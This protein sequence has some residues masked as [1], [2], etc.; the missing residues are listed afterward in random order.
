MLSA[1]VWAELS[2]WQWQNNRTWF[3]IDLAIGVLAFVLVWWRRRFPG[4]VATII[5][6]ASAVSGSAAG[7]STLALF[8]VSTRREWRLILPIAILATLSGSVLATVD[9]SL[10]DDQ[11]DSLLTYAIALL[12]TLA[13]IA[14]TVGWGMYIGSKRE[15]ARTRR[16]RERTWADEEQ[17]RIERARAAER[18]LIAR[19]MHDVLAHRISLVTM[20][21]GALTYRKDLPPEQVQQT[22]HVIHDTAHQALVELR[23]VLG[24]L[25]DDTGDALPERPQP[26]ADD[27]P[28][29]LTEAEQN[30]MDVHVQS[31]GVD[32]A[33]IP[34]VLG[35]T[36]YRIVQE[37][38]TNARKHAPGTQVVVALSGTPGQHLVVEV[39]N[40]L[41]IG[42]DHH[43]PPWQIR[44]PRA[45]SS[46]LGLVGLRERA[47]LVG[48]HLE[49]K[50]NGSIYTLRAQLP[51][52]IG[53]S[54]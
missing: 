32:P 44:G 11:P 28:S 41:P 14:I 12:L 9:G 23:E 7:P 49:H 45:P 16:E 6:I 30:G 4:P 31:G 36:A 26:D 38:L 2:V 5:T 15:L 48:G 39:R 35:R 52:P 40:H 10:G 37:G 20:H 33:Q 19:E 17:A 1:A 54:R 53:E 25:R 47:E 21:A 8:S 13:V 22:A 42:Q 29:L 27:L 3:W 46:G 24:V 18:T 34:N 51:W 50:V 43:D